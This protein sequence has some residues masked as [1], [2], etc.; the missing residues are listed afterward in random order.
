MQ[1]HANRAFQ[2]MQIEFPLPTAPT[3]A[4][5][6][7][8]V[9]LQLPGAPVAFASSATT[10]FPQILLVDPVIPEHNAPTPF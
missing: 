7:P 6:A 10:L 3:P 2:R 5:P 4:S 9:P 1:A 8:R